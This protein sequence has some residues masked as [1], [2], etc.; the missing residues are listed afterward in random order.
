M[1]LTVTE[2]ILAS[3]LIEKAAG[4]SGYAEQIGLTCRLATRRKAKKQT[5]RGKAGRRDFDK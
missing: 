4:S 2:R 3:R 5:H 1:L